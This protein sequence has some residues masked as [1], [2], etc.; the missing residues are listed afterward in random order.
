MHKSVGRAID[1]RIL[2]PRRPFFCCGATCVQ[3]DSA[4]APIFRYDST[5]VRASQEGH[6]IPRIH[7]KRTVNFSL[8]RT[9]QAMTCPSLLLA[10]DT[11]VKAA[12]VCYRKSNPRPRRTI[13]LVTASTW[14]GF[15]LLRRAPRGR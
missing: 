7:S 8:R 3:I 1:F 5:G 13:H 10:A 2:A 6:R 14:N 12:L 15:S 11:D 4:A 9:A